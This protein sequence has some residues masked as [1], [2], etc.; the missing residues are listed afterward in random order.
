VI[1]LTVQTGEVKHAFRVE[2]ADTSEAQSRGLMF[3]NELG[4][5][6]GMLFP[7]EVP[8]IRSFW[9]KNTPISLDIIFV[10]MDGRIINIA[11]ST[12]PYSLESVYSEGMTSAVL[13]LRGGTATELG[14]RSGDK[15]EYSLPE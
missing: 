5:L 2:V 6:E 15:V 3:R 11:A 9:M 7:S 1:D 8:G 10:G 13:E 4:D 12:E 14:I